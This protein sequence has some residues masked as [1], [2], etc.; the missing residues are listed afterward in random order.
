[1]IPLNDLLA[2]ARLMHSALQMDSFVTIRSG[3]TLYG[4]YAQALR[5]LNTRTRA[6]R[7]QYAGLARMLVDIDEWENGETD[8]EYD[9]R[10]NKITAAEH[11]HA[12]DECR[13]GIEETEFEFL[14]FYRQA[15][16]LRDALNGQG[17]IFPLDEQTRERLDREMWE[18]NLKCTAAVEFMSSGRLGPNTIALL[19]SLPVEM[20]QRVATAVLGQGD[21]RELIDWFMTYEPELPEPALIETQ[22]VRKL[23][24]CE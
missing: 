23:I 24:G 7:S 3:G 8:T 20:R 1:M 13:R 11:R 15:V 9:R 18:H 16:S 17:V 22:D 4:C 5:E 6:L 10:R 12:L 21:K 19:Q 2:D 14:R